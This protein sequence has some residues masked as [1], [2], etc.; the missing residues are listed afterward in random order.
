MNSIEFK[1]SGFRAFGRLVYQPAFDLAHQLKLSP[2]GALSELAPQHVDHRRVGEQEL[3]QRPLRGAA[4]VM[5]QVDLPH[6]VNYRK[7]AL[8]VV[9]LCLPSAFPRTLG[10]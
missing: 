6:F 4:L 8:C 3:G 5:H 1:R 10:K 2:D 7:P 9:F